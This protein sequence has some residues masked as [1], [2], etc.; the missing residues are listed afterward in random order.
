MKRLRGYLWGTHFHIFT[1]HKALEHFA[2]V[3]DNNARVLRWLEFLTAYSYT[4]Q[5]RKGS[6]NGNADFLSRLPI[7]AT[8]H[9]RS[10]RNRITPTDED[11]FVHLVSPLAPPVVSHDTVHFIRSCGRLPPGDSIRGIGLG[12]L[13]PPSSTAVLGGLPLSSS[14]FSDF[15]RTGPRLQSP[16]FSG[17]TDYSASDVF[18]VSGKA[19]PP[20]LDPSGVISTRTHPRLRLLLRA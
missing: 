4:L 2:K 12:G 5:Y 18:A 1:D 14:D 3:G 16:L 10:G 7:A 6:E 20:T 15:R 13:L 8:E 9:D 19:S 17:F 11:D